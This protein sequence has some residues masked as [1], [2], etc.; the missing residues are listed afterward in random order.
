MH[1]VL[2]LG[3]VE[4]GAG[5]YRGQMAV[6]VKPNG[7]LGQVYMTAIT[8]FRH[9]IVY[10][11]MLRDIARAWPAP[12]GGVRQI[13]VPAAVRSLSTLSRIDYEDAFLIDTA[14]AAEQTA[15]E[16]ARA[17]LEDA[18]LKVRGKLVSGWSALGLKLDCARSRRSVLGWPIRESSP[19]L[20][21]LGADSRI[22]MPAQ[23]LFKRE[24]EAL[25]FATFVQQDNR[26]A[27][28]MWAGTEPAHGPIVRQI[29]EGARRRA[30]SC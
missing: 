14:S 4:D 7:R 2:H 20:V 30:A 25:L 13:P 16:W 28:A 23:L 26:V 12:S 22:G 21:L 17:V 27:R 3:W 6:L 15:E 24:P 10:P 5:G 1:G 11:R 18:P 19:D 9:L 8:P 29:L